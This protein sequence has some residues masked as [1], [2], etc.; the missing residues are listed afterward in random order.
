MSDLK[1]LPLD[2]LHR[3]LGGKMVPFAGY[4]MP[5]QYPAGVM[6]EHL[7]CRSHAGLFDVSHMGQVIL[8]GSDYEAAALALESLVPVNAAGLGESRQR[9]GFFTN[10]QGGILDDLMFANR[11]DH[12]FMVVNAACKEADIA[13][14]R[15]HLPANVTLQVIE[16]R[17]LL[18]LQGPEA[19]AVLA[20]LNPAVAEMK[21]M[22]VATVDLGGAEAWISR[23]GYTGEDGFEISVPVDAAEALARKLLA[24]DRVLPIGLGARDSLRLEAGLCLYGHDID[25]GTSPVEAGLT[26]AIQKIRRSDGA[27]EGGFPGADRILSELHN[28]AERARVGLKPQ[29]RA[30]MREGVSLFAEADRETPIGCITSGGFGPTVEGPVAMG[31]VPIAFAAPGTVIYGE[32]R[33]KRLPVEVVALPFVP[34]RFKR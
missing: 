20:A 30:P 18:A 3:E 5:V 16:D 34:A 21:F 11:G 14:L 31:Y 28:G 25:T 10:E 26:W 13:H 33:G 1:S 12:I 19:E 6:K 24:D 29:G 7:H 15:A 23:S 17:A 4:D 27:R 8:R 2:G 9:Y 32:V 22:D